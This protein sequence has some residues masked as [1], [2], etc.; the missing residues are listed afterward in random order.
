VKAYN[1]ENIRKMIDGIRDN[2]FARKDT[3]VSFEY[4]GLNFPTGKDF[5]NWVEATKQDMNEIESN[6]EVKQ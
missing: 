3:N 4:Q 1:A 2:G 6:G 5:K